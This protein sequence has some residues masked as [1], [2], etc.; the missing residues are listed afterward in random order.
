MSILF[1][2]DEKTIRKHIYNVF[3]ENELHKEN[4]THFLRVIR[5]CLK[6]CAYHFDNW[7]KSNVQK[8]QIAI[9]KEHEL[10]VWFVWFEV[11]S[12]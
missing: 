12:D 4:N 3:T 5:G 10:D 11:V 2:R 9:Q 6:K 8:M 1:A 7:M